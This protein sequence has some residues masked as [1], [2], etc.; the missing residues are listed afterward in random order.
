MKVQKSHWPIFD[1]EWTNKA[2]HVLLEM[3]SKAK[4]NIIKKQT[5]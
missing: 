5:R 3:G 1:Q 2:P 4:N